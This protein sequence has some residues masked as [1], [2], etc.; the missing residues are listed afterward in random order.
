[1]IGKTVAHYK[2]LEK[3]GEGGMGVVYKAE[4]T[5]LRRFVALKFLSAHTTVDKSVIARFERE[6]QAAA[7]LSHSNIVTIHEV[8]E[9]EGQTFICMEYVPGAPLRE[10]I[11]EGP[12]PVERALA[13]AIQ[14]G[15]G[16]VKAHKSDIVHR[17]LK[18]ENI[19]ID[20]DGHVKLLDFGLAKLRG[21]T[22]ITEEA[23]T[24]GTVLYMSP[25][26]TRGDDVDHRTDIW[27][28][29][30]ILYEMVTGRTPFRGDLPGAVTYAIV[31]ESHPPMTAVRADVPIELDQFVAKAL[32]KDAAERYANVE[33]LLVDLRTLRKQLSSGSGTTS[34]IGR[35]PPAPSHRRRFLA[36]A[37]VAAV[38]L[39]IAV[40]VVFLRRSPQSAVAEKSIAVLPFENLSAEAENQYFTDGITEDIITQLSKIA[41]LRVI[42]RT[43]TMQYKSTDKTARQIGRELDVAT[44]LEGSVRRS[45]S[46]V[47]IVS[48]LIDVDTD[49]H[50]W[51]ETYDRKLEEIFKIQSDVAQSIAEALR[52]ELTPQEERRIET[53]PTENLVAYD[54]YLQGRALYNRYEK[55]DN[56]RAIEYFKRALGQDPNFALAYAGLGDAY[57]QRAGRFAGGKAWS[58]SSI[59]AARRAVELDPELAEGYKALGLAYI[60]RGQN[61]K[62]LEANRKALEF[63]PNYTT[64]MVN[65]GWL[66]IFMGRIDEAIPWLHR[67]LH[68]D[69]VAPYMGYQ[70]L[71]LCYLALDQLDQSRQWFERARA[72]QPGDSVTAFMMCIGYLTEGN[73]EAARR[74]NAD[75][76]EISPDT[77]SALAMKAW[78]ELRAGKVDAARALYERSVELTPPVEK[79]DRAERL[80]SLSH[81]VWKGGDVDAAT[82]MLE[83]A[84]DI[85]RAAMA[86]GD[87]RWEAS[88]V[89]AQV[90]AIRGDKAEA[91][92]WLG[93]AIDKGFVYYRVAE[94]YAELETLHDDSKFKE[95]MAGL[96]ERVAQMR[97]RVQNP[98]P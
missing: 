79:K 68:L 72:M 11:E 30:V 95:L 61:E 80:V 16:L 90:A 14:I 62:A 71:G 91:Y 60:V 10:L 48:Q 25:E 20:E 59:V 55:E 46:E 39:A 44:I 86:E 28:L 3:L 49:E 97:A 19:L 37:I 54:I 53:A 82:A 4:D 15:E 2:I 77:P 70:G 88:L 40:T 8:G 33:D 84:S 27:S 67:G 1:M 85:I 5:R 96:R 9:Y 34:R 22:R 75:L 78:L 81:L 69:T 17:D 38:A 32:A 31:N 29:G 47:R 24:V 52:A 65:V 64:A 57:G 13:I 73:D 58:D 76:L 21:V 7:G 12:L 35:A 63:N 89:L 87:E 56:E 92:R 23:S 6:A 51:A 50:M 66:L 94:I 36:G 93:D 26:Q 74:V 18:P 98:T 42:S 45:G 83:E 41:D 43:T